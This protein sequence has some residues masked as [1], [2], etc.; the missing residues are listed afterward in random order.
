MYAD[1]KEIEKKVARR[2]KETRGWRRERRRKDIRV[3]DK[4]VHI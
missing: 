2:I 1:G 4:Y 3:W